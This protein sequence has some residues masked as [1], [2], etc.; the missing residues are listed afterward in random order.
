MFNELPNTEMLKQTYEER[1]QDAAILR[2]LEQAWPE[3]EV[4]SSASQSNWD[5]TL[6]QFWQIVHHVGV[7]HKLHKV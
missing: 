5:E 3:D 1:L 7:T 2:R 6:N 4:V